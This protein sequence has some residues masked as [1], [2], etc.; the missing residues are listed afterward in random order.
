MRRITKFAVAGA[1]LAGGVAASLVGP[2]Q[3]AQALQGAA[4]SVGIAAQAVSYPVP[5][6]AAATTPATGRTA[7]VVSTTAP[8]PVSRT[9][10]ATTVT[11]VRKVVLSLP[12][13]ANFGT[14]VTGFA[15]VVDVVGTVSK[16]VAGLQVA[17]QQLRGLAYVQVAGGSTDENGQVPVAFTSKVNSSWR[18]VAKLPGGRTLTSPVVQNTSAALVNWAAR[19]DLDVTR[20]TPVAYTIRVNPAT[21]ARAQMQIAKAGTVLTWISARP[22]AVPAGGIMTQR[23]VFPT[24][25]TWFVRGASLAS[26]TN[27]VGTSTG[28]KVTVS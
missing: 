4:P 10:R 1:A 3:V 18:A 13:T 7:G 28:L 26:P 8:V 12:R 25:G 20:A 19:P 11:P 21:G 16:P 9:V 27:G 5:E 14:N 15:Q 2:G 17:V 22:V 6:P 24:A 23:V